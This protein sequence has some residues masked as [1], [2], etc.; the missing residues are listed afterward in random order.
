MF[1]TVDVYDGPSEPQVYHGNTLTSRVPF[2]E[3]VEAIA[4]YSFDFSV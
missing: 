3:V 1:V 2:R 4:T